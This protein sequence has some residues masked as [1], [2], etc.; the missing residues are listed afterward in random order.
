MKRIKV[1]DIFR[2]I[3]SIIICL[4]AGFIGSIF[5]ISSIPIWYATLNKP[6]FTPPNWLFAPVWTSLYILMG[7]SVFLVWK[8]GLKEQQVKGAVIIFAVQLIFNALWPVIFFGLKSPP[9]GFVVIIILWVAIL[10]TI[11]S[12]FRISKTAGLLLVPYLLW[13]S[14]AAIL[15]LSILILN[16]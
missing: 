1:N 7:I 6:F 5:T 15:N 14:F 10:L 11:R 16:M 13:T 3:I 9:A 12:F 8:K 2:L 4:S